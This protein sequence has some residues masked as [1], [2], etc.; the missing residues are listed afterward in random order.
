[1]TS[2]D[3]GFLYYEREYAG[4]P[5]ERVLSIP[6]GIGSK[7]ALLAALD[8]AAHFPYFGWNWDALDECLRDLQWIPENRIVV[9]HADLPLKNEPDE[10]A[11]YLDILKSA[12]QDWARDERGPA[13]RKQFPDL[14]YVEHTLVA[15]FPVAVRLDIETMMAPAR[16]A[17][18]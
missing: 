13:L 17:E 3:D 6:A 9:R 7:D 14:I 2:I 18:L 16:R 1:M 5:G 8:G 11:I 4:E 10:C 15:V 12:I